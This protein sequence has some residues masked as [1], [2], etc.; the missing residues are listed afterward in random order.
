[1]IELLAVID[2]MQIARLLEWFVMTIVSGAA[3]GTAWCHVLRSKEEAHEAHEMPGSWRG[4]D[5]H[6]EVQ[7]TESGSAPRGGRRAEDEA[8]VADG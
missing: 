4:R 1:M 8:G 3:L 2:R 7:G 5:T 6:G